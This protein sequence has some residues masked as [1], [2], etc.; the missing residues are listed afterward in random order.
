MR[1]SHQKGRSSLQGDLCH[2][3]TLPFRP[4]A[5]RGRGGGRHGP[6]GPQKGPG[7]GQVS[8]CTILGGVIRAEAAS[9]SGV[10]LPGPT[11]GWEGG[12]GEVVD[13]SLLAAVPLRLGRKSGAWRSSTFPS[14]LPV[15]TEV[16]T[17]LP[18]EIVLHPGHLANHQHRGNG[19]H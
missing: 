17:H 5:S 9:C 16:Q 4:R 10:C 8:S 7:P 13:G 12:G 18:R 14:S 3:H 15:G 1:L 19:P 6:Q 2:D 11:W